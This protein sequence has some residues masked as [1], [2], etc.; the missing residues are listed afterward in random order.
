MAGFHFYV[1]TIESQLP[2]TRSHAGLYEERSAAAGK[3][4]ERDFDFLTGA[5]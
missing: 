5:S 1:I 2:V 4:V 3:Q